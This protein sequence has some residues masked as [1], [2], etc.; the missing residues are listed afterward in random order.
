MICNNVEDMAYQPRIYSFTNFQF[1]GR[2]FGG[3]IYTLFILWGSIWVDYLRN[4]HWLDMCMIEAKL[5]FVIKEYSK[6]NCC[7]MLA[8]LTNSNKLNQILLLIFESQSSYLSIN[9]HFF[10]L[11][12]IFIIPPNIFKWI[13]NSRTLICISL[14]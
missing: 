14:N 9:L 13:R 11:K 5:Q 12:K 8:L 4:L 2:F 6:A 3:V 10:Q 1:W 7:C